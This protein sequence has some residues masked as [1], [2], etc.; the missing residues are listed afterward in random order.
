[1]KCTCEGNVIRLR[2]GFEQVNV[3]II[4]LK[5]VQKNYRL[6]SEEIM[7]V[8]KLR[9]LQSHALTAIESVLYAFSDMDEEELTESQLRALEKL[10]EAYAKIIEA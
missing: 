3:F 8:Y 10:Y 7:T 2:I 1:M 9:N 6:E 5:M 4:R